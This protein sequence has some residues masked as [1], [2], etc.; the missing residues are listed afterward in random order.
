MNIEEDIINLKDKMLED[1]K[2]LWEH[3]EEAFNE[4]ET[5]AYILKRLKEMGYTNI[6]TNI[7]KTGIVAEI[8]NSS[9]PCILFRADMDAVV[10]DE[11]GR[12]KHTCGHDAHMTILLT[13]ASLLMENKE[14]INGTVKLLFQPAEEGTGGAK[15]MIDEGVLENPHVDK[16]FALHVW[17]ELPK[18]S[19]GIKEGAVA[20][21]TDSF[22]IEVLGKGGHA[23]MPEKCID[24][25]YIAS[26][27]AITLPSIVSKNI[28]QGETA[29][30]GITAI[31]GGSTNNVIP[32][33]VQMKGICRT[34]N[35]D[36]KDY[37]KV[38][39]KDI[40]E[41]IAE[42]MGGKVEMTYPPNFPA[43][44]NSKEEAEMAQDIA[45]DIVGENNVITDYR[46]MCSEDFAYFLENRPGAFVFI[47][48]RGNVYYPQ[49]NENFE[50]GIEP[51]LVGV[52]FMYNLAKKY[53]F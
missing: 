4:K 33:S 48:C 9:F 40:A 1:K 31:N 22:N 18:C 23:A 49:H 32:D 14:K 46:T 41:G 45:K 17:S 7:A 34:Y 42:S 53:M 20:A 39:I 13:L 52:Q 2:F 30:V 24:P 6:K 15:P 3:P 25:I 5:S 37:I 27:I 26:Q 10:M 8:G 43:V 51:M 50:V 16:V 47:G 19:I 38:R 12:T 35:N 11:S 21:S 44:V 29:V 28:N 36:I